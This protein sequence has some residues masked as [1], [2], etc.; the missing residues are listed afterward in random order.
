MSFG[1]R[2]REASGWHEPVTSNPNIAAVINGGPRK[3]SR[4]GGALV[5]LATVIGGVCIA[6]LVYGLN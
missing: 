1:K 6:A 2:T 4:S 5:P 3:A